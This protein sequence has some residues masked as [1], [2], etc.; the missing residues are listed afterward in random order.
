MLPMTNVMVACAR[1]HVQ[2]YVDYYVP[3]RTVPI[4]RI[5]TAVDQVAADCI[6]NQYDWAWLHPQKIDSPFLSKFNSENGSHF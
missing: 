3:Q 5:R 2:H 1:P 6:Q 4:S